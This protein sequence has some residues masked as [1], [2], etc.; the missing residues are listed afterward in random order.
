MLIAGCP[1]EHVSMDF[2]GAFPRTTR[3]YNSMMVMVDLFSTMGLFIASVKTKDAIGVAQLYVREIVS[4]HGVPHNILL[5]R[6][7][8][9]TSISCFMSLM[10]YYVDFYYL[11]SAPTG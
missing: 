4:L 5:N 8:K 9:F 2:L 6:N 10:G 3:G 1:R 7:P 11:S